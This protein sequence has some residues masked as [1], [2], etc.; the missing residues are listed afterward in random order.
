MKRGLIL[1]L[2]V[3]LLVISSC[4]TIEAPVEVVE[5][6]T[7]EEPVVEEVEEAPAEV[8]EE[9]EEV[10]IDVEPLP[11]GQYLFN[12]GEPRTIE[13]M[14][15]AIT[16]MD[17]T[18]FVK[19]TIDGVEYV[20]KETKARQVYNNYYFSLWSYDYKGSKSSDTEIILEIVPFE[21][22]ENQY[23]IEKGVWANIGINDIKLEESN[24]NDYI[25]VS[26]CEAGSKLYCSSQTEIAE[27]KSKEIREQ[28]VKNVNG[29]Y[30]VSQYAIVEVTDIE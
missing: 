19:F 12:Y 13:G 26:L 1:V 23:L 17:S 29:F 28:L 25:K 27:G 11:E 10:P 5:V 9:P 22:G 7:V 8:V 18:A 2:M 16:Y 4:V 24:S 21:L 6:P 14:D 20:L 30:R 3:M 15:I